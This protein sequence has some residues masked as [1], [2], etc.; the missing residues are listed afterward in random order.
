MQKALEILLE[1]MKGDLNKQM[2]TQHYEDVS[3]FQVYVK[4]Q[5]IQIKRRVFYF[6]W[7]LTS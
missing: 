4:N 1:E 6:L 2:K 7:I 3:S 5:R